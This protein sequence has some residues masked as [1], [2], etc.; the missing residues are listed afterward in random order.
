[1][2]YTVGY[3]IGSPSAVSINRI[4]AGAL[5][6]TAP[7]EWNMVEIP[8]RDLPLYNWDL[9]NDYPPEAPRTPCRRPWPQG[10]PVS[11]TGRH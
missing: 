8:I 7:P 5:V 9:D 3:M 4:L 11:T 6:R 2:T 10:P 1:M